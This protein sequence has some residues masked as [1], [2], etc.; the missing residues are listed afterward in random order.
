MK[1]TNFGES[2]I[3]RKQ[4][5]MELLSKKRTNFIVLHLNTTYTHIYIYIK[6]KIILKNNDNFQL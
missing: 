6:L 5:V 3:K 4:I 1:L 2:I